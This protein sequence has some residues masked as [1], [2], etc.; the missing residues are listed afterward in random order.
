[1]QKKPYLKEKKILKNE[2]LILWI[3][4][5]AGLGFAIVELISAIYTH[6]QSV[7][8]DAAYDASE[9]VIIILTL[10][11]MPLF[12]KPISEKHPYGYA[13]LESVFIIV[14]S[15]MMMSVTLALTANSI[16][17]ALSGGN[18]VDSVQISVFQ[19]ALGFACLFVYILLRH[20]NKTI[21]SPTVKTE[22][23]GWK[24]DVGYSLGMSLA[25]YLSTFLEKTPLRGI[26]P[27]FDQI[28]AVFIVLSILPE[29]IKLLVRAVRD[30][31]LFAPSEEVT[32]DVQEI[33]KTVLE[34]YAFTPVF[35]DITRT[36]RRYWVSVY[37]SVE[38]EYLNLAQLDAATVELEKKLNERLL[39]CS[40]D[41]IVVSGITKKQ[42]LRAHKFEPL[43]TPEENTISISS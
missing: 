41:L 30:V 34:P 12:H 2:K 37:F 20:L 21:S 6:S 9:L 24:L 3:S 23:L 15:F 42:M 19:L 10:F 1:M 18:R 31:V 4:F 25:F 5:L 11:V 22:L 33:C 7:L 35:F 29:N 27:Y 17:I 36:G 26:A 40:A 28:V 39:S 38:G 16:N 8:M 14:K 13:Q 43:P 32:V